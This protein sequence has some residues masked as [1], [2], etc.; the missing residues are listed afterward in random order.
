MGSAVRLLITGGAGFIGHNLAL[1]FRRRGF[2]VAIVDS[3]ER[4]DPSVLVLFESLGVTFVRGDVKKEDVFGELLR[5]VDFVIHAAAYVDV[6]ESVKIPTRYIDNNVVGTTAVAHVCAECRVPIVFL[7]SAAVYGDPTTLPISEDHPLNPLSPYGLSKVL[8][9]KVV[10]FFGGQGLRYTILRLFNVYGPG[11]RTSSYT[12]VIT[13]FIERVRQNLPPVI[14]GDGKQTRDFI[15]V[16]DVARFIELVVEKR[17][18]GEV[19]NVGTGRPTKIIDLAKL[20]IKLFNLDIEPIY[21]PPRAGDVRHSY[22]D[23]NKARKLLGF[24]PSIELEEGLKQLIQ[25]P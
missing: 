11:H 12:G 13:R 17:P 3:L 24:E 14:Y 9:E 19:F 23:I 20:V 15:H 18:W 6:E 4:A 5:N 7:S 25:K 2:E 22:A 1:Y 16:L 21:K 10:E 8:G